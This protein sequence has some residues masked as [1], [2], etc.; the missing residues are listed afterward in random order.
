MSTTHAKTVTCPYCQTEQSV[1]LAESANVMRSPQWRTLMLSGRFHLFTCTQ[2]Q[3]PFVVQVD[4]LYSDFQRR[5]FMGCFPQQPSELYPDLEAKLRQTWQTVVLQEAPAKVR[6]LFAGEEDQA[7]QRVR[8][9]PDYPSLQEKV[10]IFEHDL[11][12]RLIEAMKLSLWESIPRQGPEF[13]AELYLEAVSAHG[14]LRFV[15]V[16]T[17]GSLSPMR[18]EVSHHMYADFSNQRSHLAV[19]LPSLFGST[20]QV[21]FQTILRER[22][23]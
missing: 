18:L 13:L 7:W 6:E 3:H 9:V 17:D 15:A 19:L 22:A 20:L 16:Q 10:L 14:D 12:D 5:I 21:S 23:A 8:L 2:C 1:L 4:V 11:D